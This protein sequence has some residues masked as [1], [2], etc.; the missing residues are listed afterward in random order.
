[1]DA[2]LL[3]VGGDVRSEDIKLKLPATI[4]RGKEASI[5]IPHPLISRLHCLLDEKRGW[6]VVR[7]LGSLNGTFVNNRP[8]HVSQRIHPGDLL[9]VG[10]I[11]F[12]VV[13]DEPSS[14]ESRSKSWQDDQTG[15]QHDDTRPMDDKSPRG[16]PSSEQELPLESDSH[17]RESS[18]HPR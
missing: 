18:E 8:L 9:T 1:M 14:A 10:A 12:K 3:L 2:Y 7:D 11:T 6:L 15:G 4:G 17:L 13:Y 16:E 5:T